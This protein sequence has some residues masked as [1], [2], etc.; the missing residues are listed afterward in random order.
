MSDVADAGA[1]PG[2][3]EMTGLLTQPILPS[4]IIN[5]ILPARVRSKEHNDVVFVGERRI[6]VKEA[7]P[8]G[9]LADVF[10]KNDLNGSP[11]GA[12]VI[13]VGTQLPWETQGA[14]S[15]RSI[16]RMEAES[17]A[18]QILFLALDSNELLFMYC[19]AGKEDPFVTHYRPLPRDVNTSEKY[20]RHIAVDPKYV[21]P[22]EF[23]YIE[24]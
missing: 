1:D 6:Q 10:E 23:C 2:P 18:P 24:N 11:L 13:N 12:K 21:S 7:L 4:P 5:W 16:G 9:N 19:A 8:S 22:F 14:R 17:L 15:A 3:M 20:G